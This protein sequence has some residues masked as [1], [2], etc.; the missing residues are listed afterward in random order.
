VDDWD[1]LENRCGGNSTV[2]S[3]PTPSAISAL[4]SESPGST[5][6]SLPV[7]ILGLVPTGCASHISIK[8]CLRAPS[9]IMSIPTLL[10]SLLLQHPDSAIPPSR[11][12]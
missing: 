10:H 7:S 3:N 12:S 11:R 1:G 5:P 9:L 4:H 8:A 2:G 6:R